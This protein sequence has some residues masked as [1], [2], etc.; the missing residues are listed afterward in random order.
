MGK[1][2]RDWESVF[3]L[4]PAKSA[5]LVI[6]MQNGFLEAGSPLEVPMAREQ[7]PNLKK[8]IS[9]CRSQN[10]PVIYTEFCVGPDFRYDFYWKMA[11]QRGINL[12]EPECNFWEGKHETKVYP[13]LSPFWVNESSKNV[14]MIVLRALSLIKS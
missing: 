11:S 2:Y 6:D 14:G 12:E 7:V 8:L 9:F 13:E 10:I 4:D 1:S 5:L 3:N